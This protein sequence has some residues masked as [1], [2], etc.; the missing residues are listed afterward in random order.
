MIKAKAEVL[1]SVSS[2]S[3]SK[4]CTKSSS[5][6]QKREVVSHF[7]LLL[8]ESESVPLWDAASA[9]NNLFSN[10]PLSFAQLSLIR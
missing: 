4:H 7:P 1:D 6:N 9:S 8:Y 5:S 2:A 3:S 10:F